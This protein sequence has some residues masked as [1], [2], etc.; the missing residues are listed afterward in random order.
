MPD[1][2]AFSASSLQ[3][4]H[5][6]MRT[7]VL[8]AKAGFH[9]SGGMILA[10]PYFSPSGRIFLMYAIGSLNSS[11]VGLNVGASCKPCGLVLLCDSRAASGCPRLSTVDMSKG[12][13]RRWLKGI[14]EA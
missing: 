5:I 4:E 8:I 7:S 2:A 14:W 10:T 12:G 11:S 9:E 13:A 3:P 1:L 6:G